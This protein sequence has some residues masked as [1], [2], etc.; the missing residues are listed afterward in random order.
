MEDVSIQH[1][2]YIFSGRHMQKYMFEEGTKFDIEILL[3]YYQN[4]IT[5]QNTVQIQYFN[6]IF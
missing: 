2:K 6:S 5:I 3:K 1:A 4:T